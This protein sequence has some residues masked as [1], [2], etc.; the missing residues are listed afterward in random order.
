MRTVVVESLK[1]LASKDVKNKSVYDG[2]REKLSNKV[3]AENTDM[4]KGHYN[5]LI[6]N[7]QS[8]K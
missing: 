3:A 8:I 6:K 7:L 2:V 5:I 4:S 1:V